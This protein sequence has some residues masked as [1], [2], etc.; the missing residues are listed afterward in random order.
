MTS[1]PSSNG[2][3][4]EPH[5]SSETSRKDRS[6]VLI[7]SSRMARRLLPQPWASKR[8]W[9]V[10]CMKIVP[11]KSGW[12]QYILYCRGKM[13]AIIPEKQMIFRFVIAMSVRV[14]A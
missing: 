2:T 14:G 10:S 6:P 7:C 12:S 3:L 11:S 4:R 13:V 1:K 8:M 9:P 5:I